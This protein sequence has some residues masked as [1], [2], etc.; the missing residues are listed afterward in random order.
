[1]TWLLRHDLQNI[2][3]RQVNADIRAAS[4]LS[5][6]QPGV[7]FTETVLQSEKLQQKCKCILILWNTM[8]Q[9]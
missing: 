9:T 7:T 1:M 3:K 8:Q 5:H 6:E 2:S 4:Q